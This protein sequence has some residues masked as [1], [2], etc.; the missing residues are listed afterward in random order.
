MHGTG[1]LRIEMPT[2]IGRHVVMPALAEFLARNS[3]I[4]LQIMLCDQPSDLFRSDVDAAIRI[5]P[6]AASEL[7]ASRVG[8][9]RR[10]TCAAPS[11][12]KQHG[13]PESPSDLAQQQCLA[14]IDPQTGRLEPW[15]FARNGIKSTIVPGSQLMLGDADA[16]ISAAACGLG[17][18]QAPSVSVRHHIDAGLLQPVLSDWDDD[19][20][21][22][23]YIVFP[24]HRQQSMK[25]KAFTE[26]LKQ[27]LSRGP[28]SRIRV[29]PMQGVQP[30][31][32]GE[33]RAS[34]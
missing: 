8:E 30:T 20:P 34:A 22:P 9:V 14:L 10:R 7:I 31:L 33:V 28:H 19:T 13:A 1:T 32:V 4:R 17:Y 29:L 18:V 6:L 16:A 27:L 24:R 15:T 12:I 21:L 11:F 2:M 25:I 3:S 5:G 23:I 26:F